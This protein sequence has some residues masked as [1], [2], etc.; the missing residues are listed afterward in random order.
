MKKLILGLLLIFSFSYGVEENLYLTKDIDIIKST[1]KYAF[2]IYAMH[3]TKAKRIVIDVLE[4]YESSYGSESL[5]MVSM[6]LGFV[7]IGVLNSV[8]ECNSSTAHL[9]AFYQFANLIP[10]YSFENIVQVVTSFGIVM[11]KMA[12]E[13]IKQEYNN[14]KKKR[15]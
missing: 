15:I 8:K 2:E 6:C 10:D 14:G 5:S 1:Q 9:M 3:P 13:E 7:N 11:C 4:V 12:A